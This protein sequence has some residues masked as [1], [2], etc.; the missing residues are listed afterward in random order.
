MFIY[1]YMYLHVSLFRIS[2]FKGMSRRC[3]VISFI[4][5][6]I[7]ISQPVSL[8]FDLQ[9][10]YIQ[11]S[12]YFMTNK[13]SYFFPDFFLSLKLP[14]L[15]SPPTVHI[16]ILYIQGVCTVYFQI[17]VFNDIISRYILGINVFNDM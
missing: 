13:F 11:G 16:V 1:M 2:D 12:K 7:D 4:L 14:G 5:S 10:V 8:S 15:L 9:S 3:R 6:V 17:S